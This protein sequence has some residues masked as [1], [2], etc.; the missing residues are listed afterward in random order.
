MLCRNPLLLT[1]MTGLYFIEKE[2]QPPRTRQRFFEEAI[3][4]LLTN[5]PAR[6][7]QRQIYRSE[8]KKR[9][10]EFLSLRALLSGDVADPESM[11]RKALIDEATRVFDRDVDGEILIDE[12][13]RINGIIKPTGDD[14]YTFNHRTFQE[15]FAAR[16][17]YRTK[18]PLDVA[19]GFAARPELAEV[20][21][22]YC[23]MLHNISQLNTVLRALIA[24]GDL[25]LAGECLLDSIEI[26]DQQLVEA[27]VSGLDRDLALATELTAANLPFLSVLS[28]LS[29]YT[30]PAFETAR[31]RFTAV[32][33]RILDP[34]A[35]RRRRRRQPAR[36]DPAAVQS[37]M[38]KNRQAAEKLLPVLVHNGPFEL[39][40]AA[41]RSLRDIGSPEALDQLVRLLNGTASVERAEAARMVA[42]LINSRREE[43]FERQ[44]LVPAPVLQTY[45][46]WP[47]ADYFPASLAIATARAAAEVGTGNI[48]I[49]FTKRALT[50][51]QNNSLDRRF[52]KT[53][54]GVASTIRREKRR[55]VLAKSALKL[56]YLMYVVAN[57]SA[58]GVISIGTFSG[59]TV[60][61]DKVTKKPFFADLTSLRACEEYARQALEHLYRQYPP[62]V[63]GSARLLPWNWGADDRKFPTTMERDLHAVLKELTAPLTFRSGLSHKS[64]FMNLSAPCDEATKMFADNV[65]IGSDVSLGAFVITAIAGVLSLC[66]YR[67][68]QKIL[69]MFTVSIS[70]GEYTSIRSAVLVFSMLYMPWA[71]SGLIMI[72]L[73][74]Y[75]VPTLIYVVTAF[76][77]LFLTLS[78]PW[79]RGEPFIVGWRFA[80]PQRPRGIRDVVK[81]VYRL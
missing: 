41:V 14:R 74:L 2:F 31:N 71:L 60:V 63:T 80:L 68:K 73:F 69:S 25:L 81:D 76:I 43:M 28:A 48:A 62:K 72:I 52:V 7:N 57:I 24:R 10:L 67:Y 47:L 36:M 23:G 40:G 9:I 8:D 54:R 50:Y 15:Y 35:L 26:P 59:M 17:A 75:Y 56:L 70:P 30:A 18:E 49:D 20:L 38:A 16:E 42:E 22:L 34:H 79:A 51:A 19:E 39:R 4:E 66:A 13:M 29:L 78:I 65:I 27:I 44:H 6:R 12:L 21:K 3:A 11:T 46:L 1:I 45:P 55:I 37:L 33:Q 61:I 64:Q 58:F 5:R 77:P 53:W 32:L